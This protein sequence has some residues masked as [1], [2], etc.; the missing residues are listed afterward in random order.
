MDSKTIEISDKRIEIGTELYWLY[1]NRNRNRK[2][3]DFRPIE[4]GRQSREVY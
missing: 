4:I 3:Y 1:H 2:I